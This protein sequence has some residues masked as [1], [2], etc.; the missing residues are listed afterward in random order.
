[1]SNNV[2]R[3]CQAKHIVKGLV[4][5]SERN[6]KRP[7]HFVVYLAGNSSNR[8][9]SRKVNKMLKKS[10]SDNRYQYLELNGFIYPETNHL[11]N[12]LYIKD[13]IHLNEEGNLKLSTLISSCINAADN[14]ILYLDKTD[15]VT[16]DLDKTATD[17]FDKTDASTAEKT[18]TDVTAIA[19]YTVDNDNTDTDDVTAIATDTDE[20]D[21]TVTD[22][23]D[24][25][26]TDTDDETVTATDDDDKTDASTDGKSVTDTVDKDKLILLTMTIFILMT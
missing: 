23:V 17:T 1:M 6:V 14:D 10:C 12:N 3:K 7:E 26:N 16:L 9:L 4:N 22:T 11:N 25:E 13:Y 8:E 5:K 20:D 18:V 15:T 24:N 2:F 19:N 21:E